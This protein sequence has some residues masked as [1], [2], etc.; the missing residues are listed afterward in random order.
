MNRTRLMRLLLVVGAYALLVFGGQFF[1]EHILQYLQLDPRPSTQARVNT[2]VVITAASYVLLTAA[3]FMPGIEIGLGLMFMFGPN[4]CLL[5]YLATVT[6]LTVA[7]LL[8]RLVPA[9][10]L[11]RFFSWLHFRGAEALVR[12]IAPLGGDERLEFLMS[13]VPRDSAAFLLRHRYV[14]LAILV[15]LPGNAFVGGGGGIGVAAGMSRL[16]TFP[17]YVL[18]VAIAVSPFPVLYYFTG[19]FGQFTH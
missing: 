16:F 2:V 1:S 6:A 18:T 9:E 7:F 15:N 4:I 12:Q 10:L 11:V 3:P 14:A 5:V 17:A 19:G 13:R 8:G